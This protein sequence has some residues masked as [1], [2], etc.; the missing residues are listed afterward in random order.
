MSFLFRI[1]VFII[2]L[3]YMSNIHLFFFAMGITAIKPLYWYFVAIIQAIAIAIFKLSILQSQKSKSFIVF[4]S[5]FLFHAFLSF[6]YSSQSPIAEQALITRMQVVAWFLSFLILLQFNGAFKYALSAILV[7]AILAVI[8]NIMDFFDPIWTTAPG[9]AAGLYLNANISGKMLTFVMVAGIPFIPVRFRML[10]CGFI[11]VG[12]LVT[13]SRSSWF[14]WGI[15][16]LGLVGTGYLMSRSK[17]LIFL[18]SFIAVSSILYGIISGLFASFAYDSWLFDYLTPD[19]LFRLGL[20]GGSV[21]DDSAQVRFYVAN[22]AWNAFQERPLFGFG[23]GFIYEWG[24]S[25][26]PHNMYVSILAET[27]LIGFMMFCGLVAIVWRHANSIGKVIVILFIFSSFF[28]HNNLEQ[29][30]MMMMLAFAAIFQAT[31]Y[32]L[33]RIRK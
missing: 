27:G 2:V 13:F 11:G 25:K 19:T 10:F 4:F 24:Y 7:T 18:L 15:A 29:P 33:S 31:K 9:R 26:A 30:A 8:M 23:L 14:L 17:K 12:V 1:S 28:T 5:L 16:I 22:L 21:A 3:I 32:K 20:D 6:L